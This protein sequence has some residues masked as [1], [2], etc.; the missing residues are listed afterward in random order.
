MSQ[1]AKQRGPFHSS[2]NE[3]QHAAA[4]REDA[5]P[6]IHMSSSSIM[7][8]NKRPF[9]F[10]CPWID[11][12]CHQIALNVAESEA[13]FAQ[14]PEPHRVEEHELEEGLMAV[15]RAESVLQNDIAE[16]SSHLSSNPDARTP[17][18]ETALKQLE[19]LHSKT[20]VLQRRSQ[21]LFNQAVSRLSLQE[22]RR[23]IE[24]SISTKRLTQLAYFF[25]PISLSTSVFSMNVTELRN[26]P[27]RAF[28][29]TSV[30]TLLLS[31]LLW[32]FMGFPLR[33][34]IKGAKSL[35]D[36]LLAGTSRPKERDG[37]K[38]TYTLLKFFFRSPWHALKLSFYTLFYY[39]GFVAYN[40]EA[41]GLSQGPRGPS[42]E[43]LVP[44]PRWIKP[45]SYRENMWNHYWRK[46]LEAVRKVIQKRDEL[47]GSHVH[48]WYRKIRGIRFAQWFARL[49]GHPD[50]GDLGGAGRLPQ[51]RESGD[52]SESGR[53]SG[54]LDTRDT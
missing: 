25:L 37:V 32:V 13:F 8:A 44:H 24:Q 22:S 29:A 51:A 5:R 3:L 14:R 6:T 50:P 47:G 36:D 53:A 26:P 46:E 7:A 12:I 38:N 1:L 54:S 9:D 20:E 21:I 10:I 15:E 16:L 49:R 43:L 27:L 42:S 19:A 40:F 30:I 31:F 4:N 39:S 23:S 11:D 18:T 52:Q 41:I 2:A 45:L 34:L 35:R 28:I 17:A 33:W 48:R